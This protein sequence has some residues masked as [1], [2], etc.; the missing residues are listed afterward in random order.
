METTSGPLSTSFVK[1]GGD[2]STCD[3]L[4]MCLIGVITGVIVCNVLLV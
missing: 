3:G 1:Y 4:G 2:V